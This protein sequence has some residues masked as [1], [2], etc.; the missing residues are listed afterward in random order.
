MLIPPLNT[1]M[2]NPLLLFDIQP[3]LL[4]LSPVFAPM[5]IP[6]SLIFFILSKIE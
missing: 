6:L 1:E 3:G 2:A 5:N 4:F